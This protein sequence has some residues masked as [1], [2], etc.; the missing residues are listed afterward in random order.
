MEIWNSFPTYTFG[1]I[2]PL[3]QL[4]FPGLP[5]LILIFRLFPGQGIVAI[6]HEHSK[7]SYFVSSQ[8][9]I[10]EQTE[11][12]LG[13]QVGEEKFQSANI[14]LVPCQCWGCHIITNGFKRTKGCEEG[15][16]SDA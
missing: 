4:D 14:L 6:F 1:S 15:S 10:K 7:F 16:D 13:G 12:A 3:V 2:N 5:S 9:V 8:S 11:V